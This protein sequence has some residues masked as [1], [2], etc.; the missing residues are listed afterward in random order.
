MKNILEITVENTEDISSV[1]Y[2]Y[3]EEGLEFIGK[4]N[5]RN[6]KVLLKFEGEREDISY[7]TQI[8][9]QKGFIEFEDGT[10][11]PLYIR[12]ERNFWED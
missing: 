9:D 3:Q 8:E 12:R 10:Q 5:L 11:S 4:T 2:F 1:I 7:Q 6:G